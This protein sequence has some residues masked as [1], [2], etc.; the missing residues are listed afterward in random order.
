ME[1]TMGDT[2]DLYGRI[3][4][5]ELKMQNIL[6]RAHNICTFLGMEQQLDMKSEI[7]RDF[8]WMCIDEAA[9]L[10]RQ[11]MDLINVI[12]ATECATKVL[13]HV[14]AASPASCSPCSSPSRP[15]K[16]SSSSTPTVLDSGGPP[17]TSL[18]GSATGI[19][20][21]PSCSTGTTGG[22]PFKLR[23]TSPEECV[24][25]FLESERVDATMV[26]LAL[27]PQKRISLVPYFVPPGEV[28][29]VKSGCHG[30][31]PKFPVRLLE[32][33]GDDMVD[34]GLGMAKLE[35]QP[36]VRGVYARL[37]DA[38]PPDAWFPCPPPI[39]VYCED[40]RCLWL[41]AHGD[42]GNESPDVA[43]L[44]LLNDMVEFLHGRLRH[45]VYVFARCCMRGSSVSVALSVMMTSSDCGWFRDFFIGFVR[46][47]GQ[48]VYSAYPALKTYVGDLGVQSLRV[49][50]CVMDPSVRKV[51]V[52]SSPYTCP[53]DRK[54]PS[55]EVDL[56]NAGVTPTEMGSYLSFMQ[57]DAS[58]FASS[59]AI[60][61][62]KKGS[63]RF[64]ISKAIAK[65]KENVNP[66]CLF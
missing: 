25:L 55:L 61:I 60:S 6:H 51:N 42:W 38:L 52:Y 26:L 2:S 5:L 63:K 15:S 12:D 7:L 47:K 19:L 31:H 43:L 30:L 48:A 1:G 64:K 54:D 21:V 46:A 37:C 22:A 27:V 17:P 53:L 39:R 23:L 50:D 9:G 40:I 49:L 66:H 16:S 14:K 57:V 18:E 33:L 3:A 20:T 13:E 41:Y 62:Q 59:P 44:P 28:E 10:Q 8:Y 4:S 56:R 32:V 65:D 24:R 36:W 45:Q 11:I 35:S 29:S 58:G 34:G